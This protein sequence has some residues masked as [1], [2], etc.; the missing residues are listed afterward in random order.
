MPSFV[1]VREDDSRYRTSKQLLT[2]EDAEAQR[3]PERQSRFVFFLFLFVFSLWIP[4]VLCVSAPS[5][6]RKSTKKTTAAVDPKSR[7]RRV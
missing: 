1:A 5:A 4:V 2:A 6:V 3:K 7:C